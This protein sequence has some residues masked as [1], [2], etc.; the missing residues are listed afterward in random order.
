MS[1]EVLHFPESVERG[2]KPRD[3]GEPSQLV[4]VPAGPTECFVDLSDEEI[5][6]QFRD[7]KREALAILF[8]RH[9]HA[10]HNI[11]YRILRD[12]GEAEDLVQEVFL[13]VFRKVVLFDPARGNARSW[14]MQV[15]YHRAFD[16]RRHLASRRFYTCLELEEENL[17]T[18]NLQGSA[19]WHE[20]AIEAA[21]GRETLRR[22]EASLSEMQ[23]RVLHLRFFD[24]Y[25]VDEIGAILGQS[26]G[27]VRNH[28]Y[29]ALEKMRRE[30]FQTKLQAK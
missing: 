15:A 26:P 12:T 3:T 17:P 5:L 18:E 8:R 28:Y 9:S 22:I 29:R 7:G 6:I 14:L 4:G 11:A 20:D 1:S 2:A 24:G 16:R 21:F 27:N 30:I 13:F 25:T 19:A 23:K 10:V